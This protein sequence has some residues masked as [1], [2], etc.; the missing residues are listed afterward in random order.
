MH[1]A[2]EILNENYNLVTKLN[3]MENDFEGLY[4]TDLLSTAI[5]H[6]KDKEIL[7]TIIA[8]NT[9]ISLAV[10]LDI[11]VIIIPAQIEIDEQLINRANQED[12]AIIQTRLLTHEVIIDLHERG[13]I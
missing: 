8:T 1:K 5:K 3:T 6:V 10:M 12:I 2:K 7:V 9:T 11:E 4:T 13:L